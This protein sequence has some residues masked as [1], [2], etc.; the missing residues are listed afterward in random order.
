M[1]I[2]QDEQLEF[3]S[4]FAHLRDRYEVCAIHGESH[5]S[6]R[7]FIIIEESTDRPVTVYVDSE[8]GRR[9][10]RDRYP[11]SRC[12]SAHG[13]IELRTLPEGS[14]VSVSFTSAEGPLRAVKLDFASESSPET[15]AVTYG[16]KDF[17]VWG[18]TW[19]CRGV[20]LERPAHVTGTVRRANEEEE[21]FDRAEAVIAPGSIGIIGPLGKNSR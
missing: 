8:N 6:F 4:P 18:S 20:D 16:G 13:A 3:Y 7:C 1:N 15:Q 21:R 17:P 2:N 11:E 5:G 14:E 19:Y 10:M 9:F 12:F